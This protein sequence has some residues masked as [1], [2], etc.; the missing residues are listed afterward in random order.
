MGTE[1]EFQIINP[2][3]FSLTSRS[4]DLMKYV[5]QSDFVQR[6]KPEVTQNMI[7]LNTSI[8]QSPQEMRAELISMQQFLFSLTEKFGVAFC[9]GGIH[10]FHRWSFQKIYPSSRYKQISKCYQFLIN[11]RV[12]F[13]QHIHIGCAS[14]DDAIYLT[15][16][17]SRYVPQL[18][19]MSAS[20]PFFLRKNSGFDSARFT[21]FS[22][23]PLSGVMPFSE[24]WDH[25][26]QYFYKMHNLGIVETMKDFYWDIR[27]KPEFGT[28]EIR[29]CDMPLSITKAV[30][31]VAYVQALSFFLLKER[32]IQLSPSIYDLY[33]YNRFQACRYGFDG[34][35][36]H[37]VSLEKKTVL[38]DIIETIGTIEHY[39]NKLNSMAFISQLMDDVINK[40]NDAAL[41]RQFYD[42]TNSLVKLVEK[43]CKIF[44]EP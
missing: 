29:V 32:P 30:V 41:M 34:E 11:R 22:P 20:S 12:V 16:A 13:G 38:E 14:G 33:N 15:Q 44:C 42:D 43:Q 19:A 4:K 27:P 36:I 3:T 40:K 37:P 5:K 9:G 23:F 39:A 24:N 6:I 26:T 25:F 35:F 28:V 1:L 10:P 21:F 18:I 31:L 2:R 7:E 17:L 8:C